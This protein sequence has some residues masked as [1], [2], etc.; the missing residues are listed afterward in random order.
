MAFGIVAYHQFGNLRRQLLRICHPY[1]FGHTVRSLSLIHIFLPIL[2]TVFQWI[3]FMR[4]TGPMMGNLFGIFVICYIIMWFAVPAPRTAR[5]KLEMNGEKITACLLY[6]S[7]V[8]YG[9]A[10]GRSQPRKEQYQNQ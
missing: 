10:L 4:W 2:L 7:K 5:Q 9:I 6:T 1:L 8:V 3:P